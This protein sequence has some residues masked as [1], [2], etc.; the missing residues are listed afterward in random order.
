MEAADY[1]YGGMCTVRGMEAADY[2][3]GGMCT[4]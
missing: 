4:V 2:N 3:F 1:N